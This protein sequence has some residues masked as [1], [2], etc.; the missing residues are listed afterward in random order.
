MH[1][2]YWSPEGTD[3]LPYTHTDTQTHKHWHFWTWTAPSVEHGLSVSY[4]HC[5]PFPSVCSAAFTV[6]WL[7]SPLKRLR[8]SGIGILVSHECIPHS[9]FLPF[10]PLDFRLCLRRHSFAQ[11]TF[12][13]FPIWRS[14]TGK[15]TAFEIHSKF[16]HFAFFFFLQSANK[17]R[18]M[19][20]W[21]TYRLWEFR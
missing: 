2:G 21:H 19:L 13:L 8:G 3:T 16:S 9:L 17:D 11:P 12:S 5:K 6:V 14:K 15:K 7:R 18:M 4:L 1:Q 20:I 10:H